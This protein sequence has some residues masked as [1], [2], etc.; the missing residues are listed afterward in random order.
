M[1]HSKSAFQA[2][3]LCA[4]E[5]NFPWEKVCVS[6]S[7]DMIWIPPPS[8]PQTKTKSFESYTQKQ[9]H[10]RLVRLFGLFVF[11]NMQRI[12]KRAL[13]Q[14]TQSN[15]ENVQVIFGVPCFIECVDLHA[16]CQPKFEYKII[17]MSLKLWLKMIISVKKIDGKW[18]TRQPVEKPESNTITQ[19][20]N[21]FNEHVTTF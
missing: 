1:C 12:A 21:G 18:M 16:I 15:S 17:N 20:H 7:I 13:N 19:S 9:V 3:G 6:V 4:W 10:C 14:L 2:A 5:S 11:E 8:V